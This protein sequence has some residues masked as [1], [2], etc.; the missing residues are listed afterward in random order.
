MLIYVH[1]D[2]WNFYEVWRQNREAFAQGV[3]P[4]LDVRT[5]EMFH[6]L[7]TRSPAP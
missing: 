4:G 6:E 3:P 1:D 5:L 2:T 7:K